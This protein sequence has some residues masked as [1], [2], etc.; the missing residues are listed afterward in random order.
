[1]YVY[2]LGDARNVLFE[3][4]ELSSFKLAYVR[5]DEYY[6]YMYATASSSGVSI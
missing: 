1:M 3:G 2:I 4:K 5:A 6:E